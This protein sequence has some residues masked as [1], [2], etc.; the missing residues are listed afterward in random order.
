MTKRVLIQSRELEKAADKA[1][2]YVAPPGTMKKNSSEMEQFSAIRQYSLQH[3]KPIS[4]MTP[5][6]YKEIGIRR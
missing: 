3:K 5:E 4:R 6:D 2:G 1:G